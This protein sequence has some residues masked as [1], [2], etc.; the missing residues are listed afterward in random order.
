[1]YLDDIRIQNGLDRAVP[2][3]DPYGLEQV[4]V[5]K[6]PASVL[7][8]QNSPGGLM[9]LVSK[10][11]LVKPFHELELLLGGHD[12][13]QG[14]AD[15]TA[16]IDAERKVLYRINGIVR[17]SDTQIDFVKDDRI[18]VAP[19][20][21]W[22]PSDATSLTFL[23]HYQRDRTG[24]FNAYGLPALGTV[25]TSPFGRLPKN[26][27][28]GEPTDH[29]DRDQY[30]LGYAFEHRINE[31]FKLAQNLRYLNME[32]DYFSH[33]AFSAP[34]DGRTITRTLYFF[35]E[36]LKSLGADT[37]LQG[38][39]ETGAG[40]HR[41]LLGVDYR[42]SRSRSDNGFYFDAGAPLD[43]FDPV[44][45][46]PVPD[47]PPNALSVQK[48]RQLGAYL[49]DQWKIGRLIATGGGRYD[50]SEGS[51]V[52]NGFAFED[53]KDEA[54]TGRVGLTYVLDSGVAP[55]FSYSESFEPAPGVGFD[56][57]PFVP[58]TGLQY[59]AGVKYQPPGVNAFLTLS[60]FDLK[61]RNVLTSDLEHQ[62]E[63][64][65][66]KQIGEL[67]TR[68]VEVEGKASLANLDLIVGYSY[69]DAETSKSDDGNEGMR[70]DDTPTHLASAWLTY[71]FTEG[72][73]NGLNLGGGVR[74]TGDFYGDR[75][76]EW[77]NDAETL[78]DF[79]MGYELA[80]LSDSLKGYRLSFDVTNLLN[81]TYVN[82]AAAYQCNY[83]RSRYM[84]FGMR[85][86]W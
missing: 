59:E 49:Q 54:F 38:D 82:C 36:R 11:P 5:V 66:Q 30:A 73:L 47:L 19:S 84:Q 1:M 61:Q 10:R 42:D 86:R 46:A 70:L 33:F 3:V 43:V 85:Y 18:Y 48:R 12:R 56:G 7:Y 71:R 76:E 20:L 60:V 17:D 83:G 24:E 58:T 28:I 25:Q 29:Y 9:N 64:F 79:A 15:F 68:G 27:F 77:L 81:E 62:D 63:G 16:P 41:V 4:E 67:R 26:R 75:F 37:R 13:V 57:R 53:L 34:A 45:G 32:V 2:Q 40:S 8:G 52:A 55:Y 44:Y 78:V 72:A 39:F 6:G 31:R 21:T 65:F 51:S 50:W 23:S 74:Y 69:L 35:D 14:M 80:G 22:L